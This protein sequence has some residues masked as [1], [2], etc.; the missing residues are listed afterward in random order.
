MKEYLGNPKGYAEAFDSDGFLKT[1]D[2][3]FYNE[4]YKFY[5]VTR[6]K[7]IFKFKGWHVSTKNLKL[8]K[9][10]GFELYNLY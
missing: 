3:L 4:D 6:I 2:I 1:G 10:K 8:K 7:D 9:S 5:Y